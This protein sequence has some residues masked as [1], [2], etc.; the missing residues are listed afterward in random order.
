MI[1][2]KLR[3]QLF[4]EVG[5]LRFDFRRRGF[6]VL[7]VNIDAGKVALV[8]NFNNFIDDLRAV[9]RIDGGLDTFVVKDFDSENGLDSGFTRS[10]D[11]LGD[12]VLVEPMITKFLSAVFKLSDNFTMFIKFDAKVSD[13]G[14]F[15]VLDVVGLV[16]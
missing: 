1:V 12:G 9:V 5:E 16:E 15:I 3:S 11:D 7:K 10:A 4:N 8:D 2:V 14:E 13:V 6:D